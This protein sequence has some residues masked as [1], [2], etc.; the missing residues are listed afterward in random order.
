RIERTSDQAQTLTPPGLQSV[1]PTLSGDGQRI[2]FVSNADLVPGQNSHHLDQ[3]FL[4]DAT[5]HRYTQLTHI[6]HTDTAR[7]VHSPR[8]SVGGETVVFVS[9]GDLL[10]GQ[11]QD[12]N[13]EL[14]LF[15]VSS[16][17]LLQVTRTEAPARH[18]SPLVSHD[19]QTVACLAAHPPF[20]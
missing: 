9:N 18:Q 4:F 2:A 15:D 10:S 12:A 1:S 14:F 5:A 7:A 19:G 16:G 3:V 11:N 6:R 17:Q 8:I 20:G 13:L